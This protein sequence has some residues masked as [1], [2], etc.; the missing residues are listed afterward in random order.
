M[1]YVP[2]SLAEY[3]DYLVSVM[4]KSPGDFTSF[5]GSVVDQPLALREAFEVLQEAFPYVEKKLKDAYLSAILR[6][7]LQMAYEFF[8]SGDE[9]NGI[10]AIREVEGSIWPSARI[11]PRHA[12]AAEQRAHGKVERYAGVVPSPYPFTG[13]KEDMG[14]SQR[15]L[16][17]TV[18]L[19]HTTGEEKWESGQIDN[20][21]LLPG[22]QTVRVSARSRKA[23]IA[24][25]RAEL[26]DG[27]ALAALRAENV[28]GDL[29]VYDVEQMGMPRV[30][31]RGRP[32]A[33]RSGAPNYIVDAAQWA[34][35]GPESGG[36]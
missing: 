1:R 17:L 8:A 15:A 11:P 12:P 35:A 32:E 2:S 29:F 14:P 18:W 13:S 36:G 34:V 6:A 28:Y 22:G 30:S 19:R 31:V 16:Y 3:H 21:L 5:D 23:A 20:W 7:M 9:R 24:R 33:F 27:T 10:Y 4:L 25:F 26:L